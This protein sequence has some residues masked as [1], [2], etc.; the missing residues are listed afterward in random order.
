MQ[1]ILLPRMFFRH[2][3][4]NDVQGVRNFIKLPA[5]RP[6]TGKIYQNL[7][8]TLHEM[9]QMS[10]LCWQLERLLDY[11]MQVRYQIL[12]QMWKYW[13][14]ICKVSERNGK[15]RKNERR[16]LGIRKVINENEINILCVYVKNQYKWK[17]IEISKFFLVWLFL[18]YSL[19]QKYPVQHRLNLNYC[20]SC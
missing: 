19:G 16:K 7:K 5:I 9:S 14:P 15:I 1:Q 10:L 13:V 2:S 17:N 12:L 18:F 3:S 20:H 11:H 4:D 8:K 6:G